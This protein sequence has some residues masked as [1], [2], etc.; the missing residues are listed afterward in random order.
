MTEPPNPFEQY[1]T[2]QRAG[3]KQGMADAAQRMEDEFKKQP[4]PEELPVTE[5]GVL[6]RTRSAG[7]GPMAASVTTTYAPAKERPASYPP[8]LPFLP[9]ATLSVSVF[10]D[11]A[12]GP[13][14]QTFGLSNLKAALDSITRQL[15]SAGW[16][17][18]KVPADK[19]PPGAAFS[20]GEARRFVTG[21]EGAGGSMIMVAQVEAG[22]AET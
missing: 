10:D 9:D 2:A 8:D 11:S 13:I 16:E 20:R 21:M 18:M 15:E 12:Y 1:A 17:R 4:L 3:D 22:P 6:K 14:W 19:L 7:M 5:P